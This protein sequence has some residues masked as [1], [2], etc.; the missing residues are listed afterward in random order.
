MKPAIGI[1]ALNSPRSPYARA[2]EWAGGRPIVLNPALGPLPELPYWELDGLVLTGGPDVHPSRYHQTI[3]PDAGIQTSVD[4]DAYEFPILDTALTRNIPVLAICRGLQLLNV[5]LGGSLRQDLS[6][7][8]ALPRG[9]SVYHGL[10]ILPG[11]R[12]AKILDPTVVT[13]ANSRHHQGVGPDDLAPDLEVAALVPG[14]DLIE[15][16]V[17][18]GHRWV[19]GVQCHPER[20]AE[21]SPEF[22]R[23]F[24]AFVTASSKTSSKFKED[25]YRRPLTLDP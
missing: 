4:R 16:V 5:A 17:S 12:L 20:S 9:D 10:T 6:R 24:E 25:G 22:A 19:I 1:T 3:D 8:R 21:V 11:T 2:I 15:G 23:L 14:E 7:H 18:P 13:W